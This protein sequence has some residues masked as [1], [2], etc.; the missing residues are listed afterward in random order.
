M[1][2]VHSITRLCSQC[3]LTLP[4]SEFNKDKTSGDGIRYNCRNCQKEN[5]RAWYLKN[6][7]REIAKSAQWAKD[8]PEKAREKDRR[9]NAA[10]PGRTYAQSREWLKDNPERARE[11]A[12]KWRKANPD[13][14]RMQKRRAYARNPDK[15]LAKEHARRAKDPR[16]G[17]V[18]TKDDVRR[19]Y[20]AQ[21]G[22]CACCKTVL[23]DIFERDHIVSISQGGTNDPSNIQL[24]CPPCNKRK[25]NKH[26]IDFMQEHGFLL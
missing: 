5:R 19:I 18:F 8:N 12:N 4:V 22:K 11:F 2:D 25:S 7:E 1:A 23:G 6:Q 14:L 20:A 15:F 24:L 17:L 16:T 21:R 26:P 10:R 13:K 9:R 3:R